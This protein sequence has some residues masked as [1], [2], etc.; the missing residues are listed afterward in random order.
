MILST[1]IHISTKEIGAIISSLRLFSPNRFFPLWLDHPFSISLS[2]YYF[3]P[4]SGTDS[5]ASAFF[6]GIQD[7]GSFFGWVYWVGGWTGRKAIHS[8]GK[9]IDQESHIQVIGALEVF[10]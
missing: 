2:I 6:S 10:T 9:A 4:N 3:P 7:Y 5:G 8:L 1:V